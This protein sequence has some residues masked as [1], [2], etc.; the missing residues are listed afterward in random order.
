MSVKIYR[1]TLFSEVGGIHIVNSEI[2]LAKSKK[3]ATNTIQSRW[4]LQDTSDVTVNQIEFKEA[5]IN[6][7]FSLDEN[8][9]RKKVVHECSNCKHEVNSKT[10][11]GSFCTIWNSYLA[12]EV[13]DIVWD[14]LTIN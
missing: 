6:T 1:A 9:D 2:V 14:N 4:K 7:Y 8:N 3:Q 5:Y 13:L 12:Y 11:V 10:H